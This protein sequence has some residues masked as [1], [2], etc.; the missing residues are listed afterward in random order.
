LIGSGISLAT[1]KQVGHRPLMQGV[2]LW[3]VVSV[4]SLLLIQHGWI[5][6]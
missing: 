4:T 2:L 1:L 3:L 5:R 6:L